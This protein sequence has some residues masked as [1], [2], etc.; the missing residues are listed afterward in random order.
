M[1][2]KS[3]EQ[4][5]AA[6]SSAIQAGG[7]VTVVNH[8]LTYQDAKNI[9]LDVFK[10]NF[11]EL[12][13][14]AR[15]IA[16]ERA[17][18]ITDAFL[19][20]LQKEYPEGVQKS[21][22]PDFQF[23]LLSVQ[24]EYAKS[25]DKELGDLLVDLLVDRS[26]QDQRNILQIVLNECLG[27]AS[28]LTENQ[29]ALLAIIFLFRHTQNYSVNH[30]IAMGKYFDEFVS[31]WVPRLVKNVASY[32]H[33][34]YSG[35]GTQ[36]MGEV[37]LEDILGATYHGQFVKGFTVDDFVASQVSISLNDVRYFIPCLNDPERFQVSANS[38]TTLDQLFVL[39]PVPPADKD[40]ISALFQMGKMSS[41]EIRAKCVRIRPYM[42]QVFD[43]W[44]NSPMKNFELTSVG[45]AIGHAD[46][47]RA[48]G[49]FADLSIWIN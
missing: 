44:S 10:S 32:R 20:K 27:T 14:M 18:E 49:E 33:L 16:K 8:G 40:K 28:K 36:S 39:S 19:S 11:Y 26:K 7:N 47:K 43:I 45:I 30:E 25:G 12:S 41:E 13:G 48:L 24:T 22:S 38:K 4:E 23:S 46:I 17:E 6:N 34:E 5:V 1:L 31:A 9:A 35:C 15:D 42:E 29:I 3:Q 37:Q 2:N 21:G